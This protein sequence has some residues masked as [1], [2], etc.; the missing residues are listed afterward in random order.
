MLVE[1][2]GGYTSGCGKNVVATSST[3]EWFGAGDIGCYGRTNIPNAKA[4]GV[5]FVSPQAAVGEGEREYQGF[6]HLNGGCG[7]LFDYTGSIRCIGSITQGQSAG[8]VV[9]G[10]GGSGGSKPIVTIFCCGATIKG[11]ENNG[12]VD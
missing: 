5:I 8:N 9:G 12:G 10:K 7:E 1:S 6:T 4:K 11:I 2:G 3:G